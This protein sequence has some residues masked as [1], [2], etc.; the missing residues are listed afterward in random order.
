[1]DVTAHAGPGDVRIR[2]TA[3]GET[4]IITT[5]VQR[6]CLMFSSCLLA[7][8]T[9]ARNACWRVASVAVTCVT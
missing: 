1:M 7:S 5:A 6:R 9:V 4:W 8:G 2:L 3:G